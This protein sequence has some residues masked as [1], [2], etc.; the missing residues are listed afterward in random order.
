MKYDYLVVGS[1]L[2][3][4][5]FAHEAL[6]NGRSVI[7][8]EKRDHIGG[9]IY[10]E[11]VEGINVHKYGA[12]VFHTDNREVWDYMNRFVSFNSYRH[13]VVACY[14]DRYYD[15]PFNMNTFHQLWN[16]DTPEQAKEIID[17]QRVAA[18][19]SDGDDLRSRCI[20]L[21]G[22][23]IYEILVKGYTEKQW[24]RDPELLPSSIIERLPI[25]FEYDSAYFSDRYQGIPIGGYT[26]IAEKL[27]DGIEVRLGYDFLKHKN[28]IEYD[29]LVF[30]GPIDSFFD[31]KLGH[32]EYR[33]L[34]FEEEV[35]D[36]PYYQKNSVINYTDKDIPYTRI[37]EHKHFEDRY[38]DKTVITR[39]Y[40]ESSS[41][42]REPYYPINDDKNDALYRQY[43]ELAKGCSNVIFGER[44]GEYR[45]YDMD[46]TV[47]KALAYWRSR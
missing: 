7:V 46:E 39:E 3:G 15:L 34:R 31:Y 8:A 11:N 5:V 30:T 42:S 21:I 14:K 38:S 32:L 26:Q 6:K 25:R 4:S 43:R 40:P 44:L 1:G 45:Y 10:T 18:G 33:S 2:F 16:V 24:G 36:L 17:R 23:D 28:D 29:V 22:T 37:I 47:E 41:G 12:H 20:S 9:N 35:I 27:L 19:H 13:K